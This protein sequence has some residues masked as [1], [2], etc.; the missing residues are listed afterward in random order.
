MWRYI[1][2]L[3]DAGEQVADMFRSKL[4][5]HKLHYALLLELG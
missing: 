5:A 2:D 4:S 3:A 1:T